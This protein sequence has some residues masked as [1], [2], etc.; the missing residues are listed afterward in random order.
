LPEFEVETNQLM[1]EWK[2]CFE[3]PSSIELYYR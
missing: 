1:E 3:M 2:I